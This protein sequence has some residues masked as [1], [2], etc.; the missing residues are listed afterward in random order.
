M[1]TADSQSSTSIDCALRI[2]AF[3]LVTLLL[4]AC[5]SRLTGEIYLADL[6]ELTQDD[7]LTNLISL[8]LPVSGS[9]AEDC[10][11]YRGRYDSVFR[12]SRS[13]KEMEYV[14]CH[15]EGSDTFAEYELSIPLRLTDPSE[16]RMEG[17]V[18]LILHDVVE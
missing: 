7:D 10:A 11:E 15:S 13:F 12:K 9:E 16:G 3:V 17:P 6:A 5:N 2:F 14:R 4:V 18:E 8:H 1:Y